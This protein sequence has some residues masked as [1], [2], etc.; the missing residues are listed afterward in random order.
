MKSSCT[1]NIRKII[2]YSDGNLCT[3][4]QQSVHC[5]HKI[6]VNVCV[7]CLVMAAHLHTH[8]L[9]RKQPRGHINK[10]TE[11]RFVNSMVSVYLFIAF[12]AVQN[13]LIECGNALCNTQHSFATKTYWGR[14]KRNNKSTN[15]N[16]PFPHCSINNNNS[17][18]PRCST[19]ENATACGN[20]TVST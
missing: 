18:F 10:Y 19:H 17:F 12:F 13:V 4:F 15:A 9:K 1:H 16:H 5:V 8:T 7:V 2:I 14:A 11:N 3:C 20:A 6:H